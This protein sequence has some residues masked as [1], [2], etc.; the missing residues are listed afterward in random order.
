MM[1]LKLS[2]SFHPLLDVAAVFSRI[3]RSRTLR[4]KVV[5]FFVGRSVILGLELHEHGDVHAQLGQ[6][7]N[8]VAVRIDETR[9][10]K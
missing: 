3:R 9:A 4:Q 10:D 1:R 8:Q 2:A 7:G 6:L 5:E